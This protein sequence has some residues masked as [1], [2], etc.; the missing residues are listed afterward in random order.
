MPCPNPSPADTHMQA[1]EH[2][3]LVGRIEGLLGLN[4][5][6]AGLA[7]SADHL[8]ILG[9]NEP[10]TPSIPSQRVVLPS[11]G[12]WADVSAAPTDPLEPFLGN[13]SSSGEC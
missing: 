8:S 9:P 2:T 5:H 3:W 12:P 11:S 1:H 4:S 13:G 10:R 7:T 6:M